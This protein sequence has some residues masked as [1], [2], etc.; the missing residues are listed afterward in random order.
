M[1]L[2]PEDDVAGDEAEMKIDGDE[3]SSELRMMG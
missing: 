2:H 1:R 3:V